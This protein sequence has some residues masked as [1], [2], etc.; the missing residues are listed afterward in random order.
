MK[1]LHLAALSATLLASLPVLANTNLVLDFEGVDSFAQVGSYYAGVTFS[2]AALALKYDELGPYF[3]HAPTPG[4][5]M[6]ATDSSAVM[7]VDKGFI[8]ELSFYYSAT[9]S[10][11]DVVTIYSGLNGTGSELGSISLS[12]NA[13]LGGCSDSPFC[14]WQRVSLTF[15]GTAHSASFGANGF[16]VVGFDN[17][18]ITAVPEPTSALLMALG[19][20]ALLLG[21]RKRQQG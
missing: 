2:E 10:T 5:A 8:N 7:N 4:T 17:V 1:K 20:A 11:L 6:F 3:S 13:Q 9:K 21:A 14:N 16:D 12:K 15:N 19:G 18:A